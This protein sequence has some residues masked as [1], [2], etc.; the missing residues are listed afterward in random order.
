MAIP[1]KQ[2][3][4]VQMGAQFFPSNW[5]K[6]PCSLNFTITIFHILLRNIHEAIGKALKRPQGG[7]PVERPPFEE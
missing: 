7:A 1:H 4:F 2:A 6:L 5:K 3:I